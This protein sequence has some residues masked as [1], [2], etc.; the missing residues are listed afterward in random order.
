MAG[1]LVV[2]L[3][4]A[5]AAAYVIAARA[6]IRGVRRGSGRTSSVEGLELSSTLRDQS[7][8]LAVGAGWAAA[9]TALEGASLL[10][11]LLISLFQ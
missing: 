6:F 1:L 3:N 10:A 8:E 7:R 11:I 2:F 5:A 4:L 9:G